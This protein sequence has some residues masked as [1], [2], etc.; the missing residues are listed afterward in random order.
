MRYAIHATTVATASETIA[1]VHLN[2]AKYNF[3]IFKTVS[4]FCTHNQRFQ[5]P[6]GFYTNVGTCAMRFMQRLLRQ[7]VKPLLECI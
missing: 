6:L 5:I 4:K 7:R 2:I 1:R 3:H